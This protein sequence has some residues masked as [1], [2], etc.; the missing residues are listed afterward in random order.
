MLI[1]KLTSYCIIFEINK[2]I[3]RNDYLRGWL[4]TAKVIIEK[5]GRQSL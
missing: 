3:Y 2:F 1:K 5:G 4:L